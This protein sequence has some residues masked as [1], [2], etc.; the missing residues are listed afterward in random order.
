MIGVDEQQR[1]FEDIC[2]GR[3]T[4]NG[5]CGSVELGSEG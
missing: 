2:K 3:G 5:Y 4:T 1:S